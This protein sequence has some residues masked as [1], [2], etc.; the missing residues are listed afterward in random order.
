MQKK[1]IALAIAG[2]ASTAAFAQTNVTVYGIVDMGYINAKANNAGTSKQSFSGIQSGNQMGSRV[3]FRG[4]EDLGNGLKALFTLEYGLNADVGAGSWTG[5]ARQSFLGLTG[6]FGTAVAGRLQNPGYNFASKYDVLGAAVWSP[7]GQL[8]DNAGLSISARDG[9]GRLDNAVAYISPSFSGL[10]IIA[11][12]AFGEQVKNNPIRG[13]DTDPQAVWALAAEYTL[14]D[15]NVG[16]VYHKLNDIGGTDS[17]QAEH[18]RAEYALGASYDFKV[19]KLSA[20][21]QRASD[22]NVG[23]VRSDDDSTKLWQVGVGVPVGAKGMVEVAYGRYKN[24]RDNGRADLDA[25]AWGVNYEHSL[26]PRTVAYV[27]YGRLNNGSNTAF[28]NLNTGALTS[29]GKNAAQFGLGMRH[30]F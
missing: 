21:Y 20:L 30:S 6:N 29:N 26:S 24:D 27:G 13:A 2:L 3:G 10:T 8:S 7:V 4:T 16:A 28:T 15:L 1:I 18:D 11:A 25:K 23:N 17:A 12:H 19:V 9:L 22:D 14:G 5:T